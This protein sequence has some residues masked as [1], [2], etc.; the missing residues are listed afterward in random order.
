MVYDPQVRIASPP[1]AASSSCKS[2][3]SQQ[4][5]PQVATDQALLKKGRRRSQS[6][7]TKLPENHAPERI[8]L[9][10]IEIV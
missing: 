6:K 9:S 7:A 1:T 4:I 3:W 8:I 10:L 2:L 5:M